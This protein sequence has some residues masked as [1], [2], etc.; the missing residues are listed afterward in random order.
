M[1]DKL[2][3]KQLLDLA[4]F[5]RSDM[6]EHENIWYISYLWSLLQQYDE[7]FAADLRKD[8]KIYSEEIKT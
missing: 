6:P 3:D 5:E 7:S 2:S 8:Y 4:D 1:T